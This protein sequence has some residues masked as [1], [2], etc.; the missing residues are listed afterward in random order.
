[1]KIVKFNEYCSRCFNRSRC[2]SATTF[3][4]GA[5]KFWFKYRGRK[6][7][8]NEAMKKGKEFHELMFKNIPRI[9]E[10]TPQKFLM[11][12]YNGK[13]VE[14]SELRVCSR[15]YA[16]RGIIDKFK[17]KLKDN[18]LKIEITELKSGYM[19]NYIYQLT[20]YGLIFSDPNC[21]I[22]YECKNKRG[23]KIFKTIEFYLKNR[24]S[25]KD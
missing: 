23:K 2:F 13:E 20:A 1:M 3:N 8:Q 17:A 7:E 10:I 22:S 21:L 19:K 6:E 5:R 9:E 11:D 16:L 12:L 14:V 24:K 4:Y 25:L 18:N 15:L